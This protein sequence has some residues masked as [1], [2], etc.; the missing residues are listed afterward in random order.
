MGQKSFKLSPSTPLTEL[1]KK[2]PESVQIMKSLGFDC[3][4]CKGAV[5]ETIMLAALNHGW[6]AEELIAELEK[7]VRRHRRNLA[8]RIK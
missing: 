5:H 8:K 3:T 7:G 1:F 6:K 2:Y 4:N